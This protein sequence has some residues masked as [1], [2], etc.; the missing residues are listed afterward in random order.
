MKKKEDIRGNELVELYK[1][2]NFYYTLDGAWK[3]LQ[4]KSDA[5]FNRSE[6]GYQMIAKQMAGRI[7]DSL[8]CGINKSELLSMAVGSFFPRNGKAGMD[9]ITEYA[10]SK[11]IVIDPT[12]FAIDCIEESVGDGFPTIPLD[13]DEAV[14]AYFSGKEGIPEVDIV[15]VCQDTIGKVKQV[16]RYKKDLKGGDLLFQVSEDIIASSKKT[17]KVERSK[18]LDELVRGLPM[19]NLELTQE[20]KKIMEKLIDEYIETFGEKGIQEFIYSDGRE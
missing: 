1:K 3:N 5:D 19:T 10:R 14:R 15:R 17:G 12:E 6:K 11:G 18:R 20:E 9:F 16:E 13:F 8:G 7:A 4:T 2:M